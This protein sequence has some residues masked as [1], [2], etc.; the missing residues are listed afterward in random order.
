[1]YERTRTHTH[2]MRSFEPNKC[3]VY[4]W[5]LYIHMVLKL[6]KMDSRASCSKKCVAVVVWCCVVYS[7]VADLLISRYTEKWAV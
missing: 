2:L 4:R 5:D 6:M 3:M 1:M 7:I